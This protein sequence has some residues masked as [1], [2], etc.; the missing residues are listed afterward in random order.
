[1]KK[2][3]AF[4]MIFCVVMCLSTCKK[5]KDK[6]E[7]DVKENK[8]TQSENEKKEQ[9]EKKKEDKKENSDSKKNETKNEKNSENN[10]NKNEK[11]KVIKKTGLFLGLDGSNFAVV[12]VN[13]DN[14][15]ATQLNLQLSKEVDMD[16]SDVEIGDTVNIEYT[17]DETDNKVLKKISKAD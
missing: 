6:K 13:D 9:T 3:K 10:K 11:E 8:V 15:N 4:L 12:I 1:M 14:G 2:L 7:T 16:N 17:A 5:S